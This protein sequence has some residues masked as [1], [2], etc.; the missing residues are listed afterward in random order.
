MDKE[1][2]WKKISYLLL[3]AIKSNKQVLWI[4]QASK[5]KTNI[6]NLLKE[7]KTIFLMAEQKGTVKTQNQNRNAK[8]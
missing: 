2:T 1:I 3:H 4:V 8:V 5:M 7:S 6:Y